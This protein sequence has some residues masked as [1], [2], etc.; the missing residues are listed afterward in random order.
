MGWN[1]ALS[2]FVEQR[3]REEGLLQEPDILPIQVAELETL[4]VLAENKGTSR[5]D[6]VSLLGGKAKDEFHRFS[7]LQ[8]YMVALGD[9]VSW[10]TPDLRRQTS[11]TF[12]LARRLLGREEEAGG[13]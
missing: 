3:L 4:Q 6:L 13:P 1:I 10:D 5:L 11:G 8:N 12:D 2:N 9:R 7:S